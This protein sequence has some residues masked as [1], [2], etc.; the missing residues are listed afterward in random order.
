[1]MMTMMVMGELH[2]LHAYITN[3]IIPYTWLLAWQWQNILQAFNTR[4]VWPHFFHTK[5][6]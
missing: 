6:C 2:K 3:I 4:Q 1:M 5:S